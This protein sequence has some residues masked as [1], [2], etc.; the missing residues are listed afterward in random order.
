MQS[1]VKSVDEGQIETHVVCLRAYP[2]FRLK[3]THALSETNK[4]KWNSNRVL[5]RLGSKFRFSDLGKHIRETQSNIVHSHFGD[6]GVADSPIVLDSDA[7]HIVTFYGYDVSRLP[8]STPSILPKYRKMF[9]ALK[10]VLCEGPF[11]ASKV[12]EL[13]CPEE[14]II[15]QRLGVNVQEFEFRPRTWTPG[16]TLRI[17]MA[18]AFREKKGMP[19]AIQAIGRLARTTDLELT[20]I[21]EASGSELSIQE[22][23]K[24]ELAI[25][26]SNLESRVNMLGHL[27]HAEMTKESYKHDLF[28]STSVNAS[29]GDNEGGAPVTIIEMVATGIPVVSS[30]HCDIPGV[31][32]DGETG[33]LAKE[34]DIDSIE[35][36][37]DKAISSHNDWNRMLRA[38]RTRIEQEFNL[39]KQGTKLTKIYTGQFNG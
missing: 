31:V 38:G 4:L 20:I 30:F 26:E 8:A 17:L 12:H 16:K 37:L 1:L 29:N 33:W 23:E 39:E 9:Q 2:E 7:E 19:Y 22:N 6:V 18:G 10:Y 25:K 15:V 28:V 11:M 27:P 21:G 3:N 34:R 5:G 32:L 36:C 13:G 35:D 24:I 14:K